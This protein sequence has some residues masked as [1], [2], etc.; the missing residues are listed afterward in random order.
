MKPGHPAVE[1]PPIQPYHPTTFLERGVAVPFTTPL[2]SGSRTRPSAQGGVELI[3]P[4]PSGGRGFYVLPWHTAHGL[5]Q[6]TVHDRRLHQLLSAAPVITPAAIRAAARAVAAEGLAGDDARDAALRA[7]QTD[8]GDR[9]TVNFSLLLL[10][11]EQIDPANFNACPSQ[12]DDL[13]ELAR[14]A[15]ARIAPRIGLP[16]DAIA[17]NLETLAVVF[18]AVGTQKQ[19]RTARIPR[20]MRLLAETGA[21]ILTWSRASGNI[22]QAAC[23]AMVAQLADAT[24]AMAELTSNTARA[25]TNDIVALLRDWTRSADKVGALASRPEWLLD[26]WERICLLWRTA[27][28][29]DCQRGALDELLQLLPA[30]PREAGEWLGRTAYSEIS[31]PMSRRRAVPLNQDWRTGMSVYELVARYENLRAHSM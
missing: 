29:A 10:L 1:L 22:E 4:N 5:C 30:L 7:G 6:P 9:L 11:I 13:R 15:V 17:A 18:Q 25:L 20:V 24:L 23:G 31:I 8:E 27:A 19:E 21:E 26:G 16:A 3:V 2:F 12:P 28:D 14:R